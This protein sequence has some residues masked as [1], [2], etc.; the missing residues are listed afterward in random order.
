MTAAPTP[1]TVQ[2]LAGE[3]KRRRSEL[4][5]SASEAADRAEMSRSNWF[6][7][8]GA[9][10]ERI[11]PRSL[12]SIDRALDWPIG[13]AR[14]L[15]LDIEGPASTWEDV[16][17][18]APW[19]EF[20]AEP[21]ELRN[22]RQEIKRDVDLIVEIN[23]LLR[24]SLEI[25]RTVMTQAE[26]RRYVA[27]LAQERL[28]GAVGPG[29]ARRASGGVRSSLSAQHPVEHAV[30]RFIGDHLALAGRPPAC[31]VRLDELVDLGLRQRHRRSPGV[32]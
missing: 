3:M 15:Y 1:Q 16:W 6:A 27:R 4:G 29:V 26:I 20:V 5:L 24:I 21:D 23:A 17:S 19:V 18:G 30:H 2:A 22:L 9:Q 10:R 11:T 8:E 12:R 28:N 25:K 14:A 13:Q 31:G 32:S 7:I